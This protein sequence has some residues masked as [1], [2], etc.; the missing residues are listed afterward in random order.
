MKKSFFF[1]ILF[2]TC[3]SFLTYAQNLK[4]PKNLRYSAWCYNVNYLW[5]KPDTTASSILYYKIYKDSVFVDTTSRRF[6]TLN[7]EDG[8]HQMGVSAVYEN[9]ESNISGSNLNIPQGK[10]VH[11]LITQPEPSKIR[12]R[13][14]GPYYGFWVF[15]VNC[16]E[17]PLYYDGYFADSVTY[18]FKWNYDYENN[19]LPD[20]FVGE[21][22][23]VHFYASDEYGGG[24]EYHLKIFQGDSVQNLVYFQVVDSV[25]FNNKTVVEIDPPV[26]IE[27]NADIMIGITVVNDPG[28]SN[29]GLMGIDGFNPNCGLSDLVSFDDSTWVSAGNDD[30]WI[31]AFYTNALYYDNEN[32]IDLFE[33]GNTIPQNYNIYRNGEFIGQ[34]QMNEYIDKDFTEDDCWEYFEYYVE[35]EY[36]S[37]TSALSDTAGDTLHCYVEIKNPTIAEINI[38]PNPATCSFTV[39]SEKEIQSLKLNNVNGTEIINIKP[40]RNQVTIN[41]NKIESGLY[42][43]QVKVKDRII[44]RKIIL[45]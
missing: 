22:T 42:F 14:L 13:W 32:A 3:I 17:G 9:G 44:N 25:N 16:F 7:F 15:Y 40:N 37:C 30:W 6:C 36:S 38:Y 21:F 18:A 2:I 23:D 35:A 45:L 24:Q 43:L 19:Y 1:S 27:Q 4:P 31:M 20:N 8:Y 12:I 39:Q 41:R 10:R 26:C 33:K 29:F 34:S 28:N 5:D 11:S